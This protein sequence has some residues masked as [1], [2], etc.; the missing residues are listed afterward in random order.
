MGACLA[1]TRPAES[2][3][4]W[5]S[6]AGLTDAVVENHDEALVEMIRG[7]GTRLFATEVLVDLGK[8]DLAGIDLVAAKR[9]TKEAMAAVAEH[10]LGYAIVCASKPIV[11]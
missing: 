9:L 6:G 1:D 10:R 5:P 8:L 11:S 7:I 2:Y 3:A 4:E